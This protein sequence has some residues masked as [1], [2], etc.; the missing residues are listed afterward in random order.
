MRR[1]LCRTFAAIFGGEG[2]RLDAEAKSNQ[3]QIEDNTNGA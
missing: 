1:G 2:E 3:L